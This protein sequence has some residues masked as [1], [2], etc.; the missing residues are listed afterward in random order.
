MTIRTS[1][2]FRF[3]GECVSSP[4]VIFSRYALQ[5]LW[6]RPRAYRGC[7]TRGALTAFTHNES[8]SPALQV[9][10]VP[11]PLSS[12]QFGDQTQNTPVLGSLVYRRVCIMQPS[13]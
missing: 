13:T 1:C 2:R 3:F 9:P 4:L 10:K 11:Q 12:S 5:A 7:L 6:I 8:F